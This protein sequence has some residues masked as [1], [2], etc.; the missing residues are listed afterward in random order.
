MDS[1][2][3]PQKYIQHITLDGLDGRVLNLPAKTRS[4]NKFLFIYGHHSSIERWWGLMQALNHYGSVTMPDLPGFGGMDSFYKVGKKPS[5]D[6]MAD[7]LASFIHKYMKDQEIVIAGMSF[8][9]VVA[10]RMLQRHPELSNQVKIVISIVGFVN[11]KDFTLSPIRKQVYIQATRILSFK[12]PSIIFR[13]IALHPI[14][15]NSFYSKTHNAKN[16]FK[17]ADSK[18]EVDAIK[19]AEVI[20]WHINDVRT[21]C[22]T[23]VAILTLQ[24]IKTKINLP[25]WHVGVSEDHFFDNN[26]VEKHLAE[27]FKSV[28]HIKVNAKM[29]APSVIADEKSAAEILPNDLTDRLAQL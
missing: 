19:A 3:I 5:I 13:H 14:L 23:T 20:L 9:F 1:I 6:N 8:G 22:Y 11:Q 10:T 28:L 15:L 2:N 26:N 17:E 27:I 7:Y 18:D 4:S 29:H 25:V 24:N 12:F 21:W 16:K